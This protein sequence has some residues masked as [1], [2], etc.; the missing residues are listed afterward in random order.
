MG[1]PYTI[2]D[3]ATWPWVRTLTGFYGAGEEVGFSGFANVARWLET[4]VNR[5]ASLKAVNIPARPG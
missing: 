5:P 1:E 3:I 4:C 2:A